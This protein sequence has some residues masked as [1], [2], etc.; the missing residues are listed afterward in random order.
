[1]DGE[2]DGLENLTVYSWNEN[3]NSSGKE[4][5]GLW[6]QR[7]RQQSERAGQHDVIGRLTPITR[8]GRL[9]GTGETVT[10][11]KLRQRGAYATTT[12]E[13]MPARQVG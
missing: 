7:E 1:M 5:S 9:M 10:D 8:M 11:G 12:K 2:T 3:T 4:K 13:G 6:I